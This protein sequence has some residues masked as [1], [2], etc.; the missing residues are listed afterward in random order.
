MTGVQVWVDGRLVDPA[1]ASI[2]AVDHGLTVG[3]GVFETLKVVDGV[4]FARRRHAARLQ[5]SLAGMGLPAADFAVIDAGIEAVLRSPLEFG[6]LRYTV[7][8][9][10]G[11]L[12]SDRLTGALTYV[13]TAGP[14]PRPGP[15]CTLVTV[16]WTRNERSATTGVKTTSYAENVIALA[17]AKE[18]GAD[19]AVFAN[20]AGDLCEGT[21]SNVFIVRDG[22]LSTPPAQAGPL[23]GVTRE[24]V[25]EWGREWGRTAGVEV[26]E[27][28]VPLADLATADEVFVTSSTRD[29]LPATSVDG[30]S[31][32]VGPVTTALRALF[33]RRAA[34]MVDP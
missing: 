17:Y 22:V 34:E 19:E 9:G 28:R 20:T 32:P 13:V 2:S 14:S 21:G 16:P 25:L 30:R 31:L 8:G 23:L 33:A 5:R 29:V 1:A 26:R 27:V 11:P 10:R 7:T 3:D 6:R 18:R 12:G 24:L 15:S 4:P